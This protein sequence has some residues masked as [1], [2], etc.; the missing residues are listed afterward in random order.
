[1]KDTIEGISSPASYSETT[2]KGTPLRCASSSSVKPDAVRHS[3]I[4]RDTGSQASSGTPES[5]D[6][7][8]ST[9]E[10]RRIVGWTV[11]DLVD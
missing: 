2:E 4:K 6:T 7:E 10:Y 8:G 3:W 9:P 11:V 5:F 1:V